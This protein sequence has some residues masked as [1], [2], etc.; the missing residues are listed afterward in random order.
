MQTFNAP[1]PTEL[2]LDAKTL[3]EEARRTF[4]LR[5]KKL[6]KELNERKSAVPDMLLGMIH[7]YERLAYRMQFILDR[8]CT[9]EGLEAELNNAKYNHIRCTGYAMKKIEWYD[10]KEREYF[11]GRAMVY[12]TATKRLRKLTGHSWTA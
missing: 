11:K 3:I 9:L 8:N 5:A 1:T 10:T 4:A 2:V 7:T 12:R 6:E